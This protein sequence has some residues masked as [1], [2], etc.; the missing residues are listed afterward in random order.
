MLTSQV[1][2]LQNL[3]DSINFYYSFVAIM[4]GTLLNIVTIYVFLRKRVSAK[5]NMSLLY[6]SLCFFDILT[7]L[8][9]LPFTQFLPTLDLYLSSRS[10]VLCKLV[11]I[12][13]RATTQAPSWLHVLITFDRFLSVCYPKK[14]KH[15]RRRSTL[16]CIIVII[17]CVLL[18]LNIQHIFYDI[19]ESN[20]TSLIFMNGTNESTIVFNYKRICS[21]SET[22]QSVVEFVY[23]LLRAFIPFSIKLFLN[24]KLIK[25]FLKS[26]KRS[27][28]KNLASKREKI[29]TITVIVMDISYFLLYMPWSGYF[30][31]L[32]IYK[33]STAENNELWNANMMLVQSITYSIALVNNFSS[34]FVNIVMNSIFRNELLGIFHLRSNKVSIISKTI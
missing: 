33:L 10:S 20:S 29:F 19:Y 26:K 15:F 11:M 8:N 14:M 30:I 25:C 22:L 9:S 27:N 16:I 12:Y 17:P 4:V 1:I 32:N 31:A 34:F 2:F 7:M 23:V 13:R 21:A 3:S 5:T 6:T 28:N 18:I 24:I